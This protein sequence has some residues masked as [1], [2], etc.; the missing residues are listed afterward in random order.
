[1][2]SRY[3]KYKTCYALQ[4]IFILN[5]MLKQTTKYIQNV[6]QQRVFCITKHLSVESKHFMFVYV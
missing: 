6:Y 3:I 4:T 5:D 1:M 2:Y